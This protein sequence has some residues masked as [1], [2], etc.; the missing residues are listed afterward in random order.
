MLPMTTHRITALTI[1]AAVALGAPAS[2]SAKLVYDAGLIR[3]SP[4]RAQPTCKTVSS[5]VPAAVRRLAW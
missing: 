2:A 1:A 5:S 4:K 3:T